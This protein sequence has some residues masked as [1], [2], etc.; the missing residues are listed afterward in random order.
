MWLAGVSDQW[1]PVQDEQF[2]DKFWLVAVKDLGTKR[3]PA[4]APKP[5]DLDPSKVWTYNKAQKYVFENYGRYTFNARPFGLKDLLLGE[6]D[7]FPQLRD[8][9][10]MKY[11]RYL[12]DLMMS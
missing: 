12:F 2:E 1:L 9:Q 5:K 10:L 8:A 4:R 6:K 11:E 7:V 3:A